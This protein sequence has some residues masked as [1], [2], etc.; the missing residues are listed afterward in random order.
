M[1]NEEDLVVEEVD[2]DSVSENTEEETQHELVSVEVS[3][4]ST[5]EAHPEVSS[6]T[7]NEI[8]FDSNGEDA[9]QAICCVSSNNTVYQ[10]TDKKIL[11]SLANQRRSFM[12][13]WYKS[14]PWL[15]VCATQR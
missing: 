12:I 14:Y 6:A 15:T 4:D 7:V 1:L 8:D 10:P 5:H 11:S 13:N 3:V 9:C 2:Y